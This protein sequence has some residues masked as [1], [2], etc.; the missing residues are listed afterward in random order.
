MSRRRDQCVG[1]LHVGE[2]DRRVPEQ[3]HLILLRCPLRSS[4]LR[5][6]APRRGR[7]RTASS[8]SS[9]RTRV[10]LVVAVKQA[11][12]ALPWP[13]A[14]A[15]A[16]HRRG[17][18]EDVGQPV[19]VER[20]STEAVSRPS[21]ARSPSVRTAAALPSAMPRRF[22]AP[23]PMPASVLA[24]A[25]S[26]TACCWAPGRRA[27][28]GA[29]GPARRCCGTSSTGRWSPARPQADS[30]GCSGRA[31]LGNAADYPPAR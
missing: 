22:C 4:R 20:M 26:S 3:R 7:R 24:R 13:A 30:P 1:Y 9:T 15:G 8:R 23:G 17:G 29:P 14:S 6:H 16:G 2:V 19:G 28:R 21:P 25:L 31:A 27:C 12:R 18:L 11:G 10:K 5:W